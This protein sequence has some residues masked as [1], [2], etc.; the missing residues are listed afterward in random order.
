M[1]KL[2][3]LLHGDHCDRLFS[4]KFSGSYWTSNM[5]YS[6][7][8]ILCV[9]KLTKRKSSNLASVVADFFFLGAA[10]NA[11]KF[12]TKIFR[13]C[14]TS[15]SSSTCAYFCDGLPR[16]RTNC[17]SSISLKNDSFADCANLCSSSR[18]HAL[19][20]AAGYFLRDRSDHCFV[21]FYSDYAYI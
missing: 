14:Q 6:S 15:Q 17:S 2:G 4:G 12:S 8:S 20:V 16:C 7:F 10:V 19:G 1:K 9:R 13:D 18:L 21:F 3:S 5:S 11:L